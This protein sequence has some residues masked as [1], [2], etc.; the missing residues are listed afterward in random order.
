MV[1]AAAARPADPPD[2]LQ[3]LAELSSDRS[4]WPEIRKYAASERNPERRGRAYLLLGYRQYGEKAD[5]D[6]IAN[7]RHAAATGFSLADFADFYRARAAERASWPEE[8]LA[9]LEWFSARHP[10][11]VLRFEA[12]EL[13]A[14][15]LLEQKNA[16]RAVETLLAEPR[17]R[18]RPGLAILLARGYREAGKTL[19]AAQIFQEV[20]YAHPASPEA[21]EART[22]LSTL[23][24][25]LGE[26]F[27]EVPEEIQD[28]RASILF[29]RSRFTDALADYEFLLRLRPESPRAPRW[30][31]SQARCLLALRRVSEALGVLI[32]KFSDDVEIEAERLAL[33]VEAHARLAEESAMLRVLEELHSRFPRSAAV[34]E[35]LAAAGAHYVRQGDWNSAA[36]H[37]RALV[38]GFPYSP[39]AAEAHWR[40]GWA[41]YLAGEEAAAHAAF[42]EHVRRHPDS[43][44]VPAALYR[45]ARYFEARGARAD[46]RFLCRLLAEYFPH[47]YYT[48]EGGKRLVQLPE[49]EAERERPAA[50][51]IPLRLRIAPRKPPPL[52]ACPPAET[53]YI[54]RPFR[55]LE[56]LGL[57]PLAD[58]YLRLALDV[59]PDLPHV[60][61]ALAQFESRRE[62]HGVALFAA[63]AVAPDY[64][65][66]AFDEMPEP[67]W[68]ALYPRA[69]RGL[70]RREARAN[71][72]DPYLVMALV[73]QESAFDPRATSRADARGLMQVLPRTAAG[74][75][76]RA[77][78][79]RRLYDPAYNV[80]FGCRYF[81]RRVRELDGRPEF[82]LAAYNAGASRVKRWI[83]ER[84]FSDPA[85]FFETLP[86]AETRLYVENVL[87]D[88]EIYRR[89]LTGQVK[90][91]ECARE[92]GVQVETEEEAE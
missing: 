80:R 25:A 20:F 28:A 33:L 48:L 6:A 31:L 57:D 14:G 39:P 61:L 92:A 77:R 88:A 1:F 43:R 12:L 85:E 60:R 21:L 78:V 32:P 67:F 51:L 2:R 52:D 5:E 81:S 11:S 45:L 18:Q 42:L 22:A 44:Y 24:A 30:K 27:P 65:R 19:Q 59:G 36:V 73:R 46:A 9:A 66:Y 56:S 71:G 23:R 53:P 55:S 37:S 8:A 69:Y 79:A 91:A 41:R 38:E 26:D 7:L 90:F 54:L 40:M 64:A 62:R 63:R 47:N 17:T 35:A 13:E 87:R 68:R 83:A 89:L 86:F 29:A 58:R 75:R 16:A 49:A 3:E 4:T 15:L 34:P 50:E 82:A 72:L 10:Q 84:T 74:G 70:I 76:P